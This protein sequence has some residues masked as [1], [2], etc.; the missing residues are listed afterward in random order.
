MVE[1]V[2]LYRV[3]VCVRVQGAVFRRWDGEPLYLVRISMLG[4]ALGL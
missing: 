4:G 2:Q 1:C 3:Q